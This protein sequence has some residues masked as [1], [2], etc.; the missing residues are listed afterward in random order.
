M[1]LRGPTEATV[2]A[3]DTVPVSLLVNDRDAPRRYRLI[4]RA[5]AERHGSVFWVHLDRCNAALLSTDGVMDAQNL[6]MLRQGIDDLHSMAV[7]R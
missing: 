5:V 4:L 7:T 1:Y 2:E 3:R 6:S